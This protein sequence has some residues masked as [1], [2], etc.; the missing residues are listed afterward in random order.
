[1]ALDRHRAVGRADASGDRA[2]RRRAESQ[3]WVIV[4]ERVRAVLEAPDRRDATDAVLAEVASHRLDPYTAADR[5][6][7]ALAGR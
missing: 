2:R 6:L 3:V 7:A 4:G 5:L 1:M